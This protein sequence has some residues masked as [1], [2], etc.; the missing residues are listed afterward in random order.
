VFR[1]IAL[2]A[3]G[4][5]VAG[6]QLLSGVVPGVDPN[7]PHPFPDGCAA[8]DL[9]PRRCTLIVDELARQG[10]I[11]VSDATSIDLLGDPGCLDN[12][13][14]FRPCVRTTSFVVRVR[15]HLAGGETREVSQF[16][17]VGGQYSIL[18]TETPEIEL[19]LPDQYGYHDVPCNGEPVRTASPA[20]QAANQTIPPT[21]PTP[22]PSPDPATASAE[23]P[24]LVPTLD[25][26]IDRVGKYEIVLGKGALANGILDVTTMKAADP[27]PSNFFLRGG[28]WLELTSL[29]PGGLPFDNYF[30]H[31]RVDGTEPFSAQLKFEVMA[32]DPGA[33]LQI[34]DVV[35]R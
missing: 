25:I 9:S 18:C 7:M 5:V 33:V 30:L 28:V 17:T 20:E 22:F 23:Q 27:R 21:C 2:L 6:C 13:G 31:G 8:F 12:N 10:G 1:A 24:L 19:I 16:C 29:K 4:I 34:R 35:I 26:P 15:F 11:S 14:V 32:F 3:L